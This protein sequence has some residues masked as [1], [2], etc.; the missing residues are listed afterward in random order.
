MVSIPIVSATPKRGLDLQ[1]SGLA[2]VFF[3]QKYENICIKL[4]KEKTHEKNKKYEKNIKRQISKNLTKSE[5][6]SKNLK[7]SQTVSKC[8]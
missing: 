7:K 5:N 3:N 2:M 8:L 4:K 1:W 6:I